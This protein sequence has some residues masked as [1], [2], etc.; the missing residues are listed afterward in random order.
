MV[1]LLKQDQYSPMRVDLQIVSIFAGTA[2]FLDDVPVD[3]VGR[4]EQG[5]LAYMEAEQSGLLKT[6]A[7]KKALDQELEGRLKEAVAAYKGRFKQ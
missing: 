3:A 7:E 1:E 6:I 4:F 2:G 5:L